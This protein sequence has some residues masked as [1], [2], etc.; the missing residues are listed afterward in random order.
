MLRAIGF[1]C[2]FG[3]IV[4]LLKDHSKT[5]AKTDSSYPML[6]VYTKEFNFC[7]ADFKEIEEFI[8]KKFEELKKCEQL[9]DDEIPPCTA[10]ERWHKGDVWAVMKEG[11]KTALKLCD[12]EK[13]AQEYI[14][15]NALDSKHYI[16]F[17]EGKDS[18]CD[19]Y[20]SVAE[21]CPFYKK[22]YEN[23]RTN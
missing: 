13:E 3:E 4:M 2:D 22:K 18:K 12:S 7:E 15:N 10:E 5:K 1:E 6:P 19:E 11:R 17:R 14:E 16:N 23:N 20:C 8:Y 21:H 9:S